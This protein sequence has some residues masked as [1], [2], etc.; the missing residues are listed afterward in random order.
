MQHARHPG[1]RR[2]KPSGFNDHGV[3]CNLNSH[4]QILDALRRKVAL[5]SDVNVQEY[6]TLTE[7]Y[8]G[9][10]LQALVYNAH[11]DAVH[12]SITEAEALKPTVEQSNNADATQLQFSAFGGS[13]DE[14]VL[15]RADQAV[16]ER[17]VRLELSFDLIL[18]DQLTYNTLFVNSSRPSWKTSVDEKSHI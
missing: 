3:L 11:L 1:T 6:A 10:D 5:S 15:S 18:L 17:R 4:D 13:D 2:G 7:G 14:V 9:A 16:R 8:S 12:A